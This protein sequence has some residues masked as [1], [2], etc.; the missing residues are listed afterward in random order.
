MSSFND[1]QKIFLVVIDWQILI[2]NHVYSQFDSTFKIPIFCILKQF[3]VHINAL[4]F[5]SNAF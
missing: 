4:I 3:D 5:E 2:V 1:G